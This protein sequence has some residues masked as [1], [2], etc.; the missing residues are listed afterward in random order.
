MPA[1]TILSEQPSPTTNEGHY[2]RLTG[3]FIMSSDLFLAHEGEALF[4]WEESSLFRPSPWLRNG[5]CPSRRRHW[6]PDPCACT[7]A[8]TRRC[9]HPLDSSAIR[10]LNSGRWL[11]SRMCGE[12]ETE[13]R[14]TDCQNHKSQRKEHSCCRFGSSHLCGNSHVNTLAL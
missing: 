6:R 4:C 11:A 2:S 7:S 13:F 12:K 3:V 8:L 10:N 9:W 14:G 1:A 5:V